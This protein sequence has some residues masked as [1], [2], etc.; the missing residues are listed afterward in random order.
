MIYPH[1][2]DVSL[3]QQNLLIGGIEASE[4]C[5]DLGVTHILTVDTVIPV[6]TF[7][8]SV[9]VAVEVALSLLRVFIAKIP[10]Y[11]HNR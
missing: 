9:V 5:S 11:Q 6:S 7:Y 2:I 1:N 3:V 4:A 8:S 10:S